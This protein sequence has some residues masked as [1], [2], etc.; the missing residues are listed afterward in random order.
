M[1]LNTG[2]FR[3]YK[4]KLKT[5]AEI[6]HKLEQAAGCCRFVWNEALDI[7][8]ESLDERNFWLKGL[9]PNEKKI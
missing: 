9:A 7:Q 8:K 2:I 5:T 3:D 6:E 4:L 1:L